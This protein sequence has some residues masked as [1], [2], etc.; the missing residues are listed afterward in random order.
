MCYG[1]HDDISHRRCA[2][3]DSK[4][5]NGGERPAY[6]WD[7][8]L[9]DESRWV[10][11]AGGDLLEGLT[12][13][14]R[15]GETTDGKMSCTGV[16]V[17]AEDGEEEYEVGTAALRSIR[18]S[19]ILQELREG[20]GGVHPL[21]SEPLHA[22]LSDEA[23]ERIA[24]TVSR[25]H[26]DYLRSLNG[27]TRTAGDVMREK[28]RQARVRRGGEAIPDDELLRTVRVYSEVLASGSTRLLADTAERMGWI[29]PS[30]V[31]RRLAKARRDY[32]GL[33]P[34]K[35]DER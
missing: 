9:D 25:E 34:E 28:A 16:H 18:L 20:D 24:E 8:S 23:Y 21:L 19:H 4:D 13:S 2:T 22:P 31:S 11:V 15:L 35:G 1:L 7:F 17:G 30:T 33:V 27:D 5:A 14:V 32:P 6:R 10:R 29:D 12:V 3:V 26:A